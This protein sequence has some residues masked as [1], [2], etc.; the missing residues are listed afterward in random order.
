MSARKVSHAQNHCSAITRIVSFRRGA[1]SH[2]LPTTTASRTQIADSLI[3]TEGAGEEEENPL[4]EESLQSITAP[5]GCGLTDGEYRE[6]YVAYIREKEDAEMKEA[7]NALAAPW[8]MFGNIAKKS[9]GVSAATW[10]AAGNFVEDAV[11]DNPRHIEQRRLRRQLED[12]ERELRRLN[13]ALR[14]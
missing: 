11:D 12:T 3:T 5:P 9:V 2:A 7:L 10:G 14:A 6:L 8:K 1:R 4:A 13:R